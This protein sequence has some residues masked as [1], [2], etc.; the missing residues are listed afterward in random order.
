MGQVMGLEERAETV[1]GYFDGLQKDL[2]SRSAAVPSGKRPTTYV[3]GLA[4]RGG[5]GFASTEPSY[6]PFVFL[7][8]DNV[9]SELAKSKETASH[10]TV[11][12]EQLL[13]WDPEI[14]FLDIS[15]T[16]LQAGV[17]GLEQ[18]HTDPVFRGLSAVQNGRIFGVFPY[19]YYTQN[20]G[21]I[22]ANAY[23]IGKVLYPDQFKDIDPLARAEEIT[24]FLNGGPAFRQINESF[25]N[26][27]FS[28]ISAPAH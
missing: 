11:S 27:G 2:E 19:N 26:M 5:H 28:R 18:L 25:G 21:T 9:A 24:G 20:F 1:I 8:A 22:F 10:A 23:F 17:N 6:A 15:T 14:V 4:Q 16:R 13:V 12:K 3:G 7:Q